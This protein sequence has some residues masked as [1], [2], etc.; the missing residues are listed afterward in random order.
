MVRVVWSFGNNGEDYLF[1]K[2]FEQD[3]KSIHMAVVFNQFD[4]FSKEVFGMEKFKDGF[5]INEKRLFLRSRIKLLGRDRPDILHLLRIQ[6]LEQLQ[7]LERIQQLEQLQFYSGSYEQVKIKENSII[8]CDIP[9]K[10]TADYGGFNHS[11][12]F[13]W[14]AEQS[15]PLFISE[16]NIDDKRFKQID[17]FEKRSM[18]SAN[19]DLTLI[20]KEKVYVNMAG[21]KKILSKIKDK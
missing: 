8:Y 20:K 14:A 9:Y 3:K 1:G 11:K 12:F 18:I 13:D 15:S 19:K 4:D 7:Q 2:G 6:Q 17:S 5:G 16:Y 21:Y 10:G